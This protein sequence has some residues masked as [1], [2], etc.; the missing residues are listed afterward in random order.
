MKPPFMFLSASPFAF[1]EEGNPHHHQKN[2]QP[3]VPSRIDV[4]LEFL[5]FLAGK[6][7]KQPVSSEMQIEV[8]EPDALSAEE[9]ATQ[10]SALNLLANYFDGKFQPNQWEII[11]LALQAAQLSTRDFDEN[12]SVAC[13]ICHGQN[14]NCFVCGGQSSLVAVRERGKDIRHPEVSEIDPRNPEQDQAPEITQ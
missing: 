8:V 13:P 6:R 5:N 14:K 1:G 9:V 7:R 11:E 4:A 3:I 10:D 2:N 12:G